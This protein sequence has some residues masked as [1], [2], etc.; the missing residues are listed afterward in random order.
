MSSPTAAPQDGRDVVAAFLRQSP[1]VAKLGG[2][3]EILE[4]DGERVAKAIATHKLG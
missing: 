3:A 4:A 2:V 1:F